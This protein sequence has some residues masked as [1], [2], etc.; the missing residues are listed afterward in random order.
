MLWLLL[1]LNPSLLGSALGPALP[2]LLRLL[3]RSELDIPFG[4]VDFVGAIFDLIGVELDLADNGG[5]DSDL[6]LAVYLFNP[7]D[8]DGFLPLL[9]VDA[10]GGVLSLLADLAD[11]GGGDV[12]L[13]L[14]VDL[15]APGGG[16]GFLFVL[17]EFA[18]LNGVAG[19]DDCFVPFVGDLADAGVDDCFVPFVGDLVGV[20]GV[21]CFLPLVF[22]FADAACAD[23]LLGGVFVFPPATLL[24][25][26]SAVPFGVD[27]TDAAGVECGVTFAAEA[28]AGSNFIV[29]IVIV[30]FAM[31][32]MIDDAA[33]MTIFII[34]EYKKQLYK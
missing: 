16:D 33:L 12:L 4:V 26:V 13:P 27:F 24:R 9:K 30:M 22:D 29:G 1:L 23:W 15:V 8:G 25:V 18:V 3:L 20:A 34:L 21:A 32:G 7:G 31:V 2:V 10:G 5:G 6:P 19:V 11:S 17:R 14:I 28:G